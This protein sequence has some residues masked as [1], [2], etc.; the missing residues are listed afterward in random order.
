MFNIGVALY[1]GVVDEIKVHAMKYALGLRFVVVC[2]QPIL[3]WS[4]LLLAAWVH[5]FAYIL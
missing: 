5:L 2:W 4:M 1:Y 3:L